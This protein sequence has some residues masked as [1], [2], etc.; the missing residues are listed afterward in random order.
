M[1]DVFI[2]YSQKDSVYAE[3]LYQFL[4]FNQIRAWY[5]PYK[6][7]GGNDFVED[8]SNALASNDRQE[9]QEDIEEH[10]EHL[11]SYQLVILLLSGNAMVSP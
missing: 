4:S 11:K 8:I 3:R 10:S 2:S 7:E 1:S 6:V 5:S 9:I